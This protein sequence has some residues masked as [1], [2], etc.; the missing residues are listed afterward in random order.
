MTGSYK[1]RERLSLHVAHHLAAL[2]L[3]SDFDRTKFGGHL[4]VEQALCDQSHHLAFSWRQR[5]IAAVRR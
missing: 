2:D 1:I 5:L 3:D 4:L